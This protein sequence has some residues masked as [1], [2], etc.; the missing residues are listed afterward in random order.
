MVLVPMWCWPAHVFESSALVRTSIALH[1]SQ[2][3]SLLRAWR[4]LHDPDLSLYDRRGLT[5]RYALGNLMKDL[6]RLV[7]V[8]WRYPAGLLK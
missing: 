4:S 5:R 3:Q 1:A 2:G 8:F 7:S 6:L